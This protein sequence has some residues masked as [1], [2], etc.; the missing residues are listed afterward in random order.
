[1]ARTLGPVC[2]QCRREGMKLFLKDMRC[3][4]AK[5]PIE[6]QD[7]NKPPG[8]HSWRR[9]RSSDYGVRLRE[10]QKVKRYYGVLEKQFRIYFDQAD[11]ERTNTGTALLCLLERRLDNVIVKMNFAGSRRSSRQ[12]IAHGNIHVNGRKVDIPSYLVKPGDKITLKNSE[13]IKKLVKSHIETYSG[14]PVQAWLQIDAAVPE[15]QVLAMPSRGDVL[16][17]V[18]EQL[19]VEFCSK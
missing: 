3:E 15:G 18:E 11:R 17:P 14:A 19:I 5:C 7:R 12:L 9:G 10:K 8:M 13:K 6:K 1:M 2:R 4:S 16:I